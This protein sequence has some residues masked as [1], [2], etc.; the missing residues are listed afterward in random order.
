MSGHCLHL[1]VS[2][3]L[4]TL[5]GNEINNLGYLCNLY[6]SVTGAIKEIKQVV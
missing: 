5:N 2:V 4:R 6:V 1:S 3:Q